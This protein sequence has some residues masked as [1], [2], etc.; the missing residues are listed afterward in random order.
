MDKPPRSVIPVN[1]V[2]TWASKCVGAG[3]FADCPHILYALCPSCACA[4]AAEQVAQALGKLA[5]EFYIASGVEG[6]PHNVAGTKWT[7]ADLIHA[8]VAQA[9]AGEREAAANH[10]NKMAQASPEG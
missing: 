10:L 2:I 6:G 7:P 5:D 9:R 4:Y 3:H 1:E 8:I